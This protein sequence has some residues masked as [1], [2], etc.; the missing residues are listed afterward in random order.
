MVLFWQIQLNRV[1]LSVN[2][3]H[4]WWLLMLMIISV[5]TFVSKVSLL[6][7]VIHILRFQNI[8]PS[9]ITPLPQCNL[10]HS[11]TAVTTSMMTGHGKVNSS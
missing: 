6:V 11:V 7:A 4:L 2:P 9:T 5:Q 10:C 3:N 1:M 8:M